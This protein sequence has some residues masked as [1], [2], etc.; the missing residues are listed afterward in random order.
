[1]VL[2]VMFESVRNFA[3]RSVRVLGILDTVEVFTVNIT[4][5]P[6]VDKRWQ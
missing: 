3:T 1:M 2:G 6:T 4:G 5:V